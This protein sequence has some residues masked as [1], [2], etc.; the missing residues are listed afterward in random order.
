MRKRSGL[1]LVAAAVACLAV[2]S[3]AFA[4]SGSVA[5]APTTTIASKT[6]VPLAGCS[7]LY[8]Y[9]YGSKVSHLVDMVPPAR[10]Q[11]GHTLSIAITAGLSLSATVT[12]QVS[13]DVNAIIAGASTT[14]GVSYGLTLTAQV[15]YTDTWTVPST[16]AWGSLHAGGSKDS[17]SWTYGYYSGNPCTYKTQRTGNADLPWKIPS[18]WSTQG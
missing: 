7:L 12:G 5:Q 10:A 8:G 9:K 2:P 16:W 3:P 14:F 17:M 6:P 15:T 18:F 11:G 4:D 1:A 13:G